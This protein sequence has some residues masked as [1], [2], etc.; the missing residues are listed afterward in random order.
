MKPGLLTVAYLAAVVMANLAVAQFGRAAA[1]WVAFLAIGF[2]LS[3]R[4]ALHEHWAGR[5]LVW[6]LGALITAGSALSWLLAPASGPVALASTA[7]FAAAATCDGALYHALR[8]RSR[9]AK[10]G[11]SNLAGAAADSLL[12]PA[13]AFGVFDWQLVTVQFGAKVFGGWLWMAAILYVRAS[14]E[15]RNV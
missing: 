13:I 5:W 1:P 10:M 8:A 6:R 11:W 3:A 9:A 2:D 4:D 7:A 12:F 15:V 14:R